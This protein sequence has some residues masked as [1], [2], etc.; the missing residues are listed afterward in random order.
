MTCCHGASGAMTIFC[1]TL[2]HFGHQIFGVC[3]ASCLLTGEGRLT[4][5]YCR[6]LGG[7]RLLFLRASQIQK[8]H[9]V[10][11]ASMGSAIDQSLLQ[12][13]VCIVRLGVLCAPYW[14]HAICQKVVKEN[15]G[16]TYTQRFLRSRVQT[17][18]VFSSGPCGLMFA[19]RTEFLH[20]NNVNDP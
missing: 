15:I 11:C 12:Q 16:Y 4:P 5:G 8:M 17:C 7:W 20:L 1:C 13:G 3:L 18:R 2:G 9:S 10:L 19:F 6:R 14:Q